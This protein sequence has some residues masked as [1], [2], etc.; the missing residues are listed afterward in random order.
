MCSS[1]AQTFIQGRVTKCLFPLVDQTSRLSTMT[2]C[3]MFYG[4]NGSTE[5]VPGTGWGLEWKIDQAR[6][7]G[8]LKDK[9][10]LFRH[11]LLLPGHLCTWSLC[12]PHGCFFH[13]CA[14]LAHLF[15]HVQ[16][17]QNMVLSSPIFSP[18][19]F[20][21]HDLIKLCGFIYHPNLYVQ[22]HSSKS[23]VYLTGISKLA[24]PNKNSWF[25]LPPSTSLIVLTVLVNDNSLCNCSG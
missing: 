6:L 25:S 21:L 16:G 10:P 18:L 1:L 17:P 5:G 9:W 23:L 13:S 24:C 8:I 7:A 14:D 22:P 3:D 11:S 19:L 15:L 4:S 12:L 2:Q 20:S